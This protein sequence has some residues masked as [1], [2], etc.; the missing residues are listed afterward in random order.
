MQ[1]IITAYIQDKERDIS[2]ALTSMPVWQQQGHGMRLR[3]E[4][5][6]HFFGPKE[7]DKESLNKSNGEIQHHMMLKTLQ[8]K[9]Y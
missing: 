1:C 6:L 9:I 7:E 2:P 8:N 4:N 5:M 3:A